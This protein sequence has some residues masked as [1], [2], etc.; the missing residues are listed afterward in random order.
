MKA[1]IEFKL[2]EEQSE[3]DMFNKASKM[4]NTLWE[5]QQWLRGQTKY[6]SDEA[7]EDRIKAFYDC[8]DAFN[9]L[10]SENNIQL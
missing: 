7:S 8:R 2:P 6:A 9:Q 1:I 4:Y 3:F 5:M 10:L